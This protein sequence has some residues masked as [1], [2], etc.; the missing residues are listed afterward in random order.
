MWKKFGS[1]FVLP[2]GNAKNFP[3]AVVNICRIWYI[4]CEVIVEWNF[5]INISSLTQN[6]VHRFRVLPFHSDG[7]N[8]A[9]PAGLW[10]PVENLGKEKSLAIFKWAEFEQ[11][12]L[13][14]YEQPTKIFCL[15]ENL[16]EFFF[17]I[18][19][20]SNLKIFCHFERR[21]VISQICSTSTRLHKGNRRNL[22]AF[23]TP[24]Q[25]IGEDRA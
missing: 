24:G 22:V 4:T 21:D 14:K 16:E 6:I 2:P 1:L 20:S 9:N 25:A 19:S 13:Q 5:L 12:G 23:F 7:W 8:S 3:F 17:E 18:K 15:I 10:N 11:S